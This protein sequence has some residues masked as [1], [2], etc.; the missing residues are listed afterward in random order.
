MPLRGSLRGPLKTSEKSLKTSKKLSKPLK[1]SDNPS[2]QRPSPLS[3]ALGPVAPI[4]LPL[5]L[6]PTYKHKSVVKYLP[7]GRGPQT[8]ETLIKPIIFVCVAMLLRY[9]QLSHLIIPKT[10][11][12][13]CG[14][15]PGLY[16]PCGPTIHCEL[17]LL[18][19]TK[20]TNPQWIVGH[21]GV[22]KPGR[23]PYCY[24]SGPRFRDDEVGPLLREVLAVKRPV[25][26]TSGPKNP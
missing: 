11:R 6:P 22:Y 1:T 10:G 4:R 7:S 15:R 21:R 5:K 18:L 24:L 9:L 12:F 19:R 3:E 2:F 8:S 17:D 23:E 16:T 26:I 13:T 20:Q 25:T 14:V